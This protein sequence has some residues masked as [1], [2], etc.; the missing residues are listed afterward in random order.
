MG[1]LVRVFG[2]FVLV[3]VATSGHARADRIFLEGGRVLDG[4]ATVEGDK[5]QVLLESGR[6][7]LSRSEV[8][9]VEKSTSALQEAR[10]REAA[11]RPDDVPGLLRVADFCR[12]HD[13]RKRE[14]ALLERIVSLEPDHADARRRLGF[15]REGNRWLDREEVAR[16]QRT[17]R[18]LAQQ[19]RLELAQKQAALAL[20]EAQLA[21]ERARLDRDQE[22]KKLA[23]EQESE[24]AR[25][26]SARWSPYT[27]PY[28]WYAPSVFYAGPLP[29]LSP[30]SGPPP[31]GINGV[32]HPSEGGFSIPGVKSPESA[33]EGAFRR[34]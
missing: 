11:V 6:I 21:Q 20:T 27:Q 19:T 28:S 17:E 31:F 34:R 32:R 33:F 12:D 3:F 13:L 14:R 5:V 29:R 7:S 18:D 9:R 24:R 2:A 4:E 30:P 22:Q 15:V 10:Q 16:R 23:R 8:L 1:T 25:E 26:Q